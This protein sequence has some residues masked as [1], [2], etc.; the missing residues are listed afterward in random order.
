ME[1]NANMN[2]FNKAE[3]RLLLKTREAAKALGVCEKTLWTMTKDGKIRSVRIGER[4]V[5]DGED[6][7]KRFIA[8]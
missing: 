8:R 5:R 1:N 7:L 6:D 2:E 4:R 3:V